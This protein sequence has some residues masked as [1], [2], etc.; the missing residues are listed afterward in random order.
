MVRKSRAHK[1]TSTSST[2]VFQSDRFLSP[3]NQET[4]EKLNVYKKV[5]AERKMILDE[6]D[7][8]IRRSFDRRGWLPLLDVDHPP[9]TVLIREFYLN[10][11]VHSTSSN[12]QYVKSWI[13][14]E[15][16]VITPQVV[17]SALGVP[18]VLQPVYPYDK[19]L[20]FDDIMSLITGTTIQW[21]TDPRIIF[22]E[23]TKL[24]YQFFR[25]SCHSIWPI[26]HLHTIPIER[27][28][29]LYALVTDDSICF[30][31]LFI[32]TLVEV[33]RSS[34]KRHGLFL[35]DFYS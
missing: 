16:Y 35:S 4:F 24:N 10:L 11:S 26:S 34:S 8:E 12:I 7:P 14:G 25:I 33:Y 6:F 28:A 17:A 5:W 20:P 29:F 32:S 22:H 3:K 23:L 1:K 30:P 31:S 27:Y 9:R 13:R 15:E 18:L 19:T 2:L 21:G